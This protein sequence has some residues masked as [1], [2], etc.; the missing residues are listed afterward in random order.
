M[1][2]A[3]RRALDSPPPRGAAVA[4]AIGLLISIA[5]VLLS[6][7]PGSVGEDVEWTE[8][9]RLEPSEPAELG[10]GGRTQIIDAVLSSTVAN[11]EGSKLFRL[12]AS[13]NARAGAGGEVEEIRC[14]LTV[15]KGVHIGQSEGRRAA[16]PRPLANAGDD[17]IKEGTPIEFTTEDAEL[18][19]V[20]LRN[21]FF[22][23][24]SKG[25]PEVVWT[26][27]D[28]GEHAWTWRFGS[29]VR[30]TRVN[31]A[32]VLAAE[33]GE[34]VRLACTPTAGPHSATVRTSVRLS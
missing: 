1:R 12:E 27:L 20:E 10:D 34:T 11:E 21:A 13:L 33:G 2:E 15:P 24:V 16:F 19:G 6:A 8:K 31:F 7:D 28:E 17:A 25:N 9:A 32:V 29:T 26:G 14:R 23:Y 5:A 18:A 22:S 3:I 4:V 30:N